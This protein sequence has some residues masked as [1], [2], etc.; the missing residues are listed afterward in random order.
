MAFTDSDVC[1]HCRQ[2]LC[3]WVVYLFPRSVVGE[4]LVRRVT[5]ATQHVSLMVSDET[6]WHA[7]MI[8]WLSSRREHISV[9]PLCMR[10]H[11]CTP[12]KRELTFDI[13]DDGGGGSGTAVDAE[14]VRRL[15]YWL[16]E[17]VP[18]SAV[19]VSQSSGGKGYHVWVSPPSE[20]GD[21]ERTRLLESAVQAFP[22]LPF[23]KHKNGI[24][25]YITIPGSTSRTGQGREQHL[26]YITRTKAE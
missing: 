6:S 11:P 3:P 5:V 1:R 13:D 2:E 9:G 7:L 23:D 10:A 25:G 18:D 14:A 19:A 15:A 22:A 17:R 12:L 8:G 20:A 16:L 26:Y 21:F 24:A 4:P